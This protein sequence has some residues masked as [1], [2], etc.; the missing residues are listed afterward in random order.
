MFLYMNRR[1]DKPYVTFVSSE[2]EGEISTSIS[3]RQSTENFVDTALACIFMLMFWR[4][5]LLQDRLCL[6]LGVC[7]YDFQVC[8]FLIKELT[9]RC[10]EMHGELKYL[11][12]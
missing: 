12:S 5:H 1:I 3:T 7:L 10:L 4:S 8:F 11:C 2:N 6:R 9:S